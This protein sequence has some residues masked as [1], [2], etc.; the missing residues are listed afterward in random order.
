MEGVENNASNEN[1]MA[2][3]DQ[4]QIPESA[5]N[6][7]TQN[8][9]RNGMDNGRYEIEGKPKLIQALLE[10]GLQLAYTKSFLF[11][12]I[13]MAVMILGYLNKLFSNMDLTLKDFE[14]EE[15]NL[16]Y[17]LLAVLFS[18]LIWDLFL[19]INKLIFKLDKQHSFEEVT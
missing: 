15:M 1:N 14:D 7:T 4:A 19:I 16:A 10:K 9:R 5:P 18:A 12:T 8:R 6:N 2:Q 17:F 3:G 11:V 13:V